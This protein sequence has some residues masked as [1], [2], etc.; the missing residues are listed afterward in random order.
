MI[1]GK[2][3]FEKS[4]SCYSFIIYS[5][6]VTTSLCII[7]QRNLD[8]SDTK[9]RILHTSIQSCLKE[10]QEEI[11]ICNFHLM[12]VS[13]YIQFTTTIMQLSSSFK[14]YCI[15]PDGKITHTQCPHLQQY[16]TMFLPNQ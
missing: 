6:F 9:I 4:Y 11:S 13:K 7:T 10:I 16:H 12:S 1:L 3:L 2:Q 14:L 8:S 15:K 5:A